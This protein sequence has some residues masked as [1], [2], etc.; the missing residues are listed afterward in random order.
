MNRSLIIL[1][2][3]PLFL[4]SS[5]AQ[6]YSQYFDGGSTNNNLTVQIDPG[7]S[8]VWEIGTPAKIYF[9]QASTI[10]NAIVTKLQDNYPINNTSSFRFTVPNVSAGIIAIQWTQKLDYAIGYDGGLVEFSIDNDTT[11]LNAFSSPYVYIF[12]GFNQTNKDTIPGGDLAFTGTDTTW[13]DI[14]LCF[15]NSF[16]FNNIELRFTSKSTKPD[17]TR[18]GWLIDNISVHISYLH[19]IGELEQEEY[20]KV[21]PSLTTGKVNI[22]TKKIN[23]FHIIEKLELVNAEGK[24]IQ[25][26][27]NIPTKFWIDIADQPDGQ[28]FLQVTT[29][30]KSETFPIVLQK[31]PDR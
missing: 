17:S 20:L 21:Y 27:I 3:A 24:I 12:N 5:T 9:N 19:T 10:P 13:R 28:Y 1:C 8:N 2:L 23:G 6:V 31:D 18:E 25:Q 15:D 22:N 4:S 14:W 29:N 16:W 7:P 11:W 30:V 26:H